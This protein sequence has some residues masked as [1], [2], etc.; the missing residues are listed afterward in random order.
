MLQTSYV[1]KC[2][3]A[4]IYQIMEVIKSSISCYPLGLR[5]NNAPADAN[6]RA[7]S[8]LFGKSCPFL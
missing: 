3:V 5:N 8:D 1:S 7:E 6:L 4:F 2:S